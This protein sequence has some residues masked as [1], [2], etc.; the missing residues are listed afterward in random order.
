MRG[1]RKLAFAAFVFA[2]TSL[3]VWFGKISET[4]YQNISEV[5]AMAYLAANSITYTASRFKGNKNE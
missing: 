1:W 4:V 5:I 2:V 3:F